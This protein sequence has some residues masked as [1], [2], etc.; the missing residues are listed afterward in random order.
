ML[1]NLVEKLKGLDNLNKLLLSVT[2][3]LIDVLGGISISLLLKNILSLFI[4]L[5]TVYNFEFL[6]DKYCNYKKK[7]CYELADNYFNKIKENMDEKQVKL[8]LKKFVKKNKIWN[9]IFIG[10]VPLSFLL[11]IILFCFDVYLLNALT[12][13]GVICFSSVI[14]TMPCMGYTSFGI[15]VLC[16]VIEKIEN[17]KNSTEIAEINQDADIFKE[18]MAQ[19][20]YNTGI[21]KNRYK[22]V[23]AVINLDSVEIIVSAEEQGKK[24]IRVRERK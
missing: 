5:G 7:Y 22:Y 23:P 2:G 21:S 1:G 4:I 16:E 12:Y 15:D 24:N 19:L 17:S 20:T 6:L 11:A 10:S 3:L 14:V 8:A 9:G 18:T 13:A